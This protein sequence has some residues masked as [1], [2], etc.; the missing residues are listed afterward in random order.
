MI[1]Y[2]EVKSKFIKEKIKNSNW[3]KD[4]EHID[5]LIFL[6]DIILGKRKMSWMGSFR[7]NMME[8]EFPKE[9]KIIYMELKPEIYKK[10]I[11]KKRKE[12]LQ[13]EKEDAEFESEEKL[14]EEKEKQEWKKAGGKI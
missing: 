14:Q 8:R 10:M 12:K 13:Q 6:E 7:W 5:N 2:N 4:K 3:K 9:F 1:K 11:A